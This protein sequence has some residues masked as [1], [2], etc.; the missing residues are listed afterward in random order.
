MNTGGG[1]ALRPAPGSARLEEGPLRLHMYSVLGSG[2]LANPLVQI[3]IDTGQ[4]MTSAA[5]RV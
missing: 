1:V 5:E 3:E 2:Q 4:A